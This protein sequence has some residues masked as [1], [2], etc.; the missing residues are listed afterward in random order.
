MKSVSPSGY[1]NE[2][3]T[4]VICDECYEDNSSYQES[5][6]QTKDIYFNNMY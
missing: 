2:S 6:I 4:G 3:I 5:N 1:S